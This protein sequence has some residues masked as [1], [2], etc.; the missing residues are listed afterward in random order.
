MQTYIINKIV[1]FGAVFLCIFLT[2]GFFG[3]GP[4]QWQVILL[5]IVIFGYGHFLLGYFYQ[6]KSFLR[7][8]KPWHYFLTFGVLTLFSVAFAN[9][10]TQYLS[11]E[12]ALFVGF[13]YFLFHGLFNEQTLIFRQTNITVPL[14]FLYAL[15]I[16]ILGV[17]LYSIPDQTFFFD[18]YLEFASVTNAQAQFI[19][20]DQYISLTNLAAFLWGSIALSLSVLLYAWYRYGFPRLT[21]F[22][23]GLIISGIF[24]IETY[25][26]PAYIYAYIVVVGYHFMTW[27]LFYLVEMKKR[28]K[29]IFRNFVLHNILIL[30]PL[31]YVATLFLLPYPPDVA[32]VVFD[33]KYFVIM[34]YIHITTSFMNDSWMQQ[35]QTKTFAF[36]GSRP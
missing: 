19:F 7:K 17:I 1:S 24:L 2:L 16:F 8:Q 13:I 23:A 34:T 10:I 32:Y 27:M 36:F 5:A 35:L 21:F 29:K 14:P 15:L 20:A 22:L 25:G 3:Y 33:Y 28:G 12:I 6:L 30:V 18:R 11:L 4:Q 9:G 26:S 31:V